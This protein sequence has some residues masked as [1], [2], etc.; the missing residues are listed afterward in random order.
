[1]TRAEIA[2]ADRKRRH[3]RK[4]IDDAIL[5]TRESNEIIIVNPKAPA[6]RNQHFARAGGY[7]LMPPKKKG[8][9]VTTRPYPRTRARAF[10]H[11]EATDTVYLD[12]VRIT[13]DNTTSIVPAPKRE[14]NIARNVKRNNVQTIK[15]N[16]LAAS[17]CA[18]F[19]KI[20]TSLA[21]G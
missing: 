7:H 12:H 20:D 4:M 17:D 14:R 11:D 2:R 6:W 15:D 1:M 18:R 10:V 5:S 21:E 9:Y 19:G 8:N 16:S 3:A 13:K